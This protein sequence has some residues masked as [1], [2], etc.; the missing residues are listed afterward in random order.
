[1]PDLI[2][3]PSLLLTGLRDWLA[4]QLPADVS[5]GTRH[6]LTVYTED[7]FPDRPPTPFG[8]LSCAPGTT[9]APVG[10]TWDQQ[11]V[12]VVRALWEGRTKPQ[13]RALADLARW[14][15]TGRTRTGEFVTPMPLHD[16]VS[17]M[18]RAGDDDGY[19]D[20]VQGRPQWAET[21]RVTY[22]RATD[23]T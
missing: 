14:R 16:A 18:D 17:V 3:Q 9:R 7:D 21:F 4:A 13:T 20:V 11:G 19:L 2:Y 23:P 6:R 12:L 8:L 10:Q 5:D 22:Q 1:M 15:F